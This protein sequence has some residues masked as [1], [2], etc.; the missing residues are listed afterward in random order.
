[1]ILVSSTCF[2]I[3]ATSLG[4]GRNLLL[5]S[6]GVESKYFLS[7]VVFLAEEADE[8]HMQP[9]ASKALSIACFYA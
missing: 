3:L 6:L 4:F 9:L 7:L 5:E 1:M 8:D 2:S